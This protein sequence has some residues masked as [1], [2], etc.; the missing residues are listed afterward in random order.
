[1]NLSELQSH[2]EE[3][4]NKPQ[5][6]SPHFT[7]NEIKLNLKVK[8]STEDQTEAEWRE[9]SADLWFIQAERQDLIQ[10]WFLAMVS[11]YLCC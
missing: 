2:R 6:I 8:H 1:M 10:Y 4:P 3:V 11:E 5:N 9:Q 7:N